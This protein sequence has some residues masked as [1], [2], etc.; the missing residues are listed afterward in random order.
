MAADAYEMWSMS[1]DTIG[2]SFTWKLRKAIGLV[3]ADHAS[4]TDFA[5]REP[6]IP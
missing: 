2:Q 5:P 3:A 4:D 1:Y 6:L